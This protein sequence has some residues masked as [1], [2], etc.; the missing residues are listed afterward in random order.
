VAIHRLVKHLEVLGRQPKQTVELRI[1][2]GAQE[3]RPVIY[4]NILNMEEKKEPSL[5]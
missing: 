2:Y 3:G 4:I 5:V 1:A